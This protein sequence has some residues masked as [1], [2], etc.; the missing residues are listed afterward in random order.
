M[1]INRSNQLSS[2]SVIPQNTAI[3][4]KQTLPVLPQ[5]DLDK[6][7]LDNQKGI[8]STI[9][10]NDGPQWGLGARLVDAAFNRF[11][12][13]PFDEWD[14]LND[15]EWDLH[16]LSDWDLK[17]ADK[18]LGWKLETAWGFQEKDFVKDMQK[19]VKAEMEWRGVQPAPMYFDYTPPKG[20][21]TEMYA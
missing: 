15:F 21:P 19:L 14:I 10:G 6:F 16:S 17:R 20:Q 13:E 7:Q 11:K 1:I 3:Q 4:P 12:A 2:I 9:F 18:H 5:L 8:P